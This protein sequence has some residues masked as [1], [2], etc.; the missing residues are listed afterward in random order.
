LLLTQFGVAPDTVAPFGDDTFE[1]H[2]AGVPELD[3]A[4]GFE[5]LAQ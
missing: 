5:V 2:L 4:V 3:F 1:T